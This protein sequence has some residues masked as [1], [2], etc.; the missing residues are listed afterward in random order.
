M[1]WRK[2]LFS[3]RTPAT[4]TWHDEDATGRMTVELVRTRCCSL[5]D[6]GSLSNETV[7]SSED[8][9]GGVIDYT[10]FATMKLSNYTHT[11]PTK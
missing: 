4:K 10:A 6:F 11:I 8:A 1:A 3:S 7:T 5:R 2:H 9:N